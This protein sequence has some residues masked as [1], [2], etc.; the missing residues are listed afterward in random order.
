M[1]S[2]NM[3]NDILLNNRVPQELVGTMSVD[4]LP[5]YSMSSVK[6][7]KSLVSNKLPIFK[8]LPLPSEFTLLYCDLTMPL[9][10]KDL[11]SIRKTFVNWLYTFRHLLQYYTVSQ[12]FYKS[13]ND[14]I[15]AFVRFCNEFEE[16][17]KYNLHLCNNHESFS[18]R[19]CINVDFESDEEKEE[20]HISEEEERDIELFKFNL[21]W[22]IEKG[23]LY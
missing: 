18:D 8:T 9:L 3:F 23:S 19:T 12:L 14:T 2:D 22:D 7:T 16:A 11:V 6:F 5:I 13:V 21:E 17:E 1:I 10:L 20:Y 15:N 4:F